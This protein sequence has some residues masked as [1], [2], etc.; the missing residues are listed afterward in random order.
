MRERNVYIF[1]NRLCVLR[2]RREMYI[3][4]S[5]HV[6]I[7]RAVGITIYIFSKMFF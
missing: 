2:I 7:D 6:L 4:Q 5:L 3:F 1:Q